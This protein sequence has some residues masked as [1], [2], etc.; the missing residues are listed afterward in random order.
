MDKKRLLL[1]GLFVAAVILIAY[2]LYYFFW[3]KPAALPKPVVTIPAPI[4]P[5]VLPTAPVGVPPG[6]I[7]ALPPTAMAL[8]KAAS[9]AQGGLTQAPALTSAAALFPTISADGKNLNYYDPASGKFYRVTPD[10]QATLLSAASFYNVQKITWGPQSDKAI[11]EYPDNSKILYNFTTQKQATLPKHWEDFS[12]TAAGN[13][14]AAKSI[15]ISPENRWLVIAKDDGSEAKVIE[16]LGKN[17]DKVQVNWSPAG[18]VIAFAATG[19]AL[20]FARKEIIPLGPNNENYKP[21]IVEGFDFQPKWAPSGEK[22][23]YSTFN[24]DNNYHPTLWLTNA[25]GEQMGSGRHKLNLSTWAEKCAFADNDT[26]FCAV[27]N[28]LEKGIGFVPELAKQSPDTLYKV[29][30]KTNIKTVVAAPEGNPSMSNLVISTDKSILYFTNNV[31]GLL[32]KIQL[33]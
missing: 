15:G 25:Q 10:G 31:T 2:G 9:I 22:L 16:P 18:G 3:K 17:A 28:Q 29:N 4:A 5:G 27:P 20:G 23:L 33:K 32:H 12:F 26:V 7:P 6:I 11:L 30:L 14:I 1:I 19:D 8:P 24:Q 21:L 13:Q